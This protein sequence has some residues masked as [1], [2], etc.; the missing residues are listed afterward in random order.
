M[1]NRIEY[2]IF[3]SFSYL[4]KLLGLKL[5][6]K[7]ATILAV[8]FYY[9]IPIRKETVLNNLQN[10][11]PEYSDQKINKIA[12]GS[13]KSFA[14]ALVELLYMPWMS[15][16]EM[17]KSVNIKNPNLGKDL[18]EKGNG[19][20]FLSA[21][22]GNWEFM[23]ASYGA[24]LN[25][26]ISLVVKA[27]RNPFVTEWLN[28]IRTKWNNKL[29]PLGISIR[30]IYKELKDKNLVAMIAD[31]R[32]PSDGIRVDFFGRKASVYPGP[33]LLALKTGAPIVYGIAVRNPDNSYNAVLEEISKEN[34]P[35]K[36]EEKVIELS[37]R[38]TSYL[39]NFIRQHPEQWL[40][41]HKR[42]KY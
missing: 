42:W 12:Y 36:E 41:M 10:A 28:N 1:Q 15:L 16:E 29:V 6:R 19:V 23:A 11:F 35:E 33:A 7:F 32:G 9:I 25:I 24:Q 22:Y 27:Q 21:H 39:E 17:K 37:Q 26:P 20:V 31:Q 4:F 14:L 18:H 38:H 8:L 30:Q 5:S 34:L 40:W 2:I 3:L 13:Y